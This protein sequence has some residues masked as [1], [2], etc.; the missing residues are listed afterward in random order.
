MSRLRH[1]A[2]EII[3]T[4]ADKI[5]I[6]TTALLAEFEKKRVKA[7]RDGEPIGYVAIAYFWSLAP[8]GIAVGV[9]TLSEEQ[10]RYIASQLTMVSSG[11][12]LKREL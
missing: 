9:K 3:Q 10:R 1:R 11:I 2:E 7:C 6:N 12:G 5:S 8:L 4:M